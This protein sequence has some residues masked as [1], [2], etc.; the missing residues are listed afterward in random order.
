[1]WLKP[2]ISDYSQ[3]L[4]LSWQQWRQGEWWRDCL[5]RALEPHWQ[6][7]F[8]HYLVH[9]GALSALTPNSCRIRE[10]YYVGS[11]LL[12]ASELRE[13]EEVQQRQLAQVVADISAL[14]FTENS[15]DAVFMAHQLE[16]HENPH[17]LL[18]EVNRVLRADGHVVIAVTNPYSPGQ[19]IRAVPAMG[20]YP[21]WQ[22]RLFSRQRVLDWLS[23]MHYEEVASGYF[24]AG[25]PWSK[26]RDPE[27]GWGWLMRG[28]SWAQSGYYIVARKR[29]WPLTP[30][31][32]NH[33][34]QRQLRPESVTARISSVQRN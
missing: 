29:E 16:H 30:V 15:I 12:P 28:C 18:R 25:V 8:G 26:E 6:T 14:P 21:P 3:P 33:Q 23:L 7:I 27:Q 13:V 10:Q 1:M 20:Q 31:R 24:A 32:L 17:A 2:A 22:S 34:R 11:K 4:L 19:L 5:V 9:L